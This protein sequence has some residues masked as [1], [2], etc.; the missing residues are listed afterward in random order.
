MSKI[1]LLQTVDPPPLLS[2]V[3][4]SL[5]GKENLKQDSLDLNKEKTSE[6]PDSSAKKSHKKLKGKEEKG[7]KG[8]KVSEE[9][10][11]D[12]KGKKNSK[13]RPEWKGPYVLL[14]GD[15]RSPRTVNVVNSTNNE[16]KQKAKRGLIESEFKAKSSNYGYSSTLSKQ[17]DFKTVDDTWRCV[18]CNQK[19]HFKRLGDLFGPYFVPTH[20]LT[21][22]E[23]EEKRPK[24]KRRSLIAEAESGSSEIWF[25]E[26][27]FCWIPGV[28]L[29]G[30]RI[31]GMEEGVSVCR[32]TRCIT[33]NELGASL[34]CTMPGCRVATHVPCSY[35]QAWVTDMHNFKAT[36]PRCC[37]Q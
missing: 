6:K 10:P 18:F 27:C 3:R 35:Q 16:N 5:R 1:G 23:E 4:T 7:K 17:Y 28:H 24:S 2:P 31:V 36:C 13:G 22:P 30:S 14:E 29:V 9:I 12:A 19:S 33:C 34:G 26:D 32:S 20:C 11:P 37:Q 8:K 25:H 15:F 21:A